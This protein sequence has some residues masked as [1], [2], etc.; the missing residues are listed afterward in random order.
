MDKIF[1]LL[2]QGRTPN[3]AEMLEVLNFIS[4]IDWERIE[5]SQLSIL[6]CFKAGWVPKYP[7]NCPGEFCESCG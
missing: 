7:R 6:D 4:D 5:A 1:K 3:F 2:M